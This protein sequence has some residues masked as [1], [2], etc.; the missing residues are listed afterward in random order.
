[1]KV[2]CK[3]LL[4]I[5]LK[6]PDIFGQWRNTVGSTLFVHTAKFLTFLDG[7]GICKDLF[8]MYWKIPDIFGR[9]RNILGSTL[10]V[11]QNS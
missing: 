4:Y 7:G 9:W 3:D 10:S 11:Q 5:Y 6:I 2:I 8:Y 1:M